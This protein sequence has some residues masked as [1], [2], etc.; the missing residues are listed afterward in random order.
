MSSLELN[1]GMLKTIRA[2]EAAVSSVTD[3]VHRL[4]ADCTRGLTSEEVD[5]RRK[6]HGYNEFEI[7]EEEPLWKKYLKQVGLVDGRAGGH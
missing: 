3:V 1:N 6:V 7:N 2:R 4:H 5:L